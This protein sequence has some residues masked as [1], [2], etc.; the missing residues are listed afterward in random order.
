MKR[1]QIYIEP[2]LDEAL[3]AEAARTGVSKAAIIRRLVARHVAGRHAAD[4][5][6]DLV[7]AFPGDPG[8]VDD[9]IYGR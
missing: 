4:P 8:D 5:I 9:V 3:G 1:L 7:G 6:D 2:E